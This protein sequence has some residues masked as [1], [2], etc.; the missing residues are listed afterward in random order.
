[1]TPPSTRKL[2]NQKVSILIH[3]IEEKEVENVSHLF[4]S[5]WRFFWG[6]RQFFGSAFIFNTDP[7]PVKISLRIRI[8]LKFLWGSG[9]MLLVNYE[10]AIEGIFPV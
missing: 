1:M 2:S 4:Y 6:G 3:T 7:G 8:Q 5:L 10:I 9:S